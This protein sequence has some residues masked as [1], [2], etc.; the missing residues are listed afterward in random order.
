MDSHLLTQLNAVDT[1]SLQSSPSPQFTDVFKF[2]FDSI[3]PSSLLLG[4]SRWRFEPAA[5][6]K[7]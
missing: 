7:G 2:P 1:R 3:L 4:H 6:F 5:R